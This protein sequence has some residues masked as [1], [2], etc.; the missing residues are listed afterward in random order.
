MELKGNI[1][2]LDLKGNITN[3]KLNG[4]LDDLMQIAGN[5]SK[6]SLNG[7]LAH[8][9]LSGSILTGPPGPT[10]P[11][12]PTGPQGIPG[13]QGM[14]GPQGIAGPTGPKGDTGPQGIQGIPGPK[15]DIGPQG[16]Q[17]IQGLTG[18]QG[19]VGPQGPKGDKGDKGDQGPQG[20]R[21]ETGFTGETGP[22]GEVGPQGP[23]GEPGPQG[24][25]GPPGPQGEPGTG[26]ADIGDI[27]NLNTTN[28][29][30]VVSAINEINAKFT[31]S[32][33]I[34]T[35]SIGL[36]D[37]GVYYIKGTTENGEHYQLRVE[38][39]T[40]SYE[41][42]NGESWSTQ[43]TIDIHNGDIDSFQFNTNG[44]VRFKNG[45]QIAWKSQQVVAGGTSW[46]SIYYS[47]HNL[48]NWVVPFVTCYVVNPYCNATTYWTTIGNASYSSAGT[49]RCFRPNSST[50][51]IWVGATGFGK[52]K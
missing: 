43:W 45:F 21:G 15:G 11:T 34:V 26:G 18:P 3:S 10:G 30:D 12:G 33:N 42:Y 25:Q 32:Q 29:D 24:E 14:P 13:P 27:T 23:Q 16:P 22:Q 50:S 51:T 8:K 20:E 1:S 9:N 40:L 28:K 4:T 46:G 35:S 49:I 47:D 41:T 6:D 19:E 17:G 52:W 36:N 5:L 2:K 37:S 31:N 48:G 38:N 39:D 44:Y 7:E